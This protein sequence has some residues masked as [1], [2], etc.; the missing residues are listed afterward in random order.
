MYFKTTPS[1]V[2]V[3]ADLSH[4][5]NT[6]K[7]WGA[8]VFP[9]ELIAFLVKKPPSVE[10]F[11]QVCATLT[12]F[13]ADYNLLA[14]YKALS[15]CENK[16]S[17][18]LKAVA[19]CRRSDIL[20]YFVGF[21]KKASIPMVKQAAEYGLLE[22][23]KEA[24]TALRAKDRRNPFSQVCLKKVAGN[25]HT[26][27]LLFLLEQGC[28]PHRGISLAAAENGHLECLQV[29]HEHGC[30]CDSKILNAAALYDQL[31]CVT[32]LLEQGCSPDRTSAYN[33][34]LN[35][36]LECLRLLIDHDAPLTKRMCNAAA[37]NGHLS[38]LQLLFERG[39]AWDKE[40][41]RLAVTHNH[42]ECLQYAVENGC[43]CD[44][45]VA[46]AAAAGGYLSCL[47]YLL[48]R[49]KPASYLAVEHAVRNGHVDCV[50]ALFNAG[51]SF[52]VDS[53]GMEH[54]LVKDNV[55]FLQTYVAG[56]YKL[57]RYGT[58][59]AAEHGS[60]KCLA[61]ICSV[62]H[63]PLTAEETSCA[64]KSGQLE[65]LKI[66]RE[67]GCPWDESVYKGAATKGHV[68][69][70]QYAVEHGCPRG[71]DDPC[72]AA[73]GNA[74]LEAL[75][76]LH[77]QGFPL[78]LQTCRC[79]IRALSLKCMGFAVEHGAPLDA[80][81]CVDAISENECSVARAM[82]FLRYL[83][84]AAR[85]PWDERTAAAAA[86]Y[87][88]S[89]LQY[90]HEQGCPWDA[91]T[92]SAAAL[93]G[94]LSCLQ[95]AL[96]HGC[97]CVESVCTQAATAQGS[98]ACLKALHEHG[99]EW[100]AC[101]AKAV[102]ESGNLGVMGYLYDQGCPWDQR[103][104]A[105]AAKNGHLDILEFAHENGCPWD[106]RTTLAAAEAGNLDCLEYAHENGCPWDETVSEAAALG[107]DFEG[108]ECFE[109]CYENHCPMFSST[110]RDY[111]RY[112]AGLYR[113]DI[114]CVM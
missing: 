107:N 53:F 61:F 102:A 90:V 67:H 39:C 101:T 58:E 45:S 76:Y 47:E 81:L 71:V 49:H 88:L 51:V 2:A 10:M 22:L 99:C 96:A 74:Q 109:Y 105:A 4:L 104:P 54:A 11:D 111:N 79:A 68:E 8:Q 93:Q 85:C 7:F 35:G 64:A 48:S 18:Q 84:E 32:Y 98:L 1:L 106:I 114:C 26:E 9:Q 34:A 77:S 94:C 25:G 72:A 103:T 50:R 40:C 13:D 82:E 73:A 55:Q 66:L 41:A 110:L 36:H 24:T 65:C 42:F 15:A 27:C 17:V 33:A 56:G 95:Y 91:C 108:N 5:L 12:E 29:A 97:P 75:Q 28:A 113:E 80:I 78:S 37:T 38:C 19:L 87:A 89:V 86:G 70:L 43:R 52:S 23:L 30:E 59:E 14:M 6:I 60:V 3:P 62:R 16:H 57:P 92:T 83:R 69:C 20:E 63:H 44:S 21:N 46:D 100:D 112:N 31:S